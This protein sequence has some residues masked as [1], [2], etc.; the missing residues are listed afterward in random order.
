MSEAIARTYWKNI[1]DQ[2]WEEAEG[3]LHRNFVAEWPQSRER[4]RRA[5]DFIQM[6][7]EYPG[8]H[9]VEVLEALSV[10]DRTVTTVYIHAE[11]TGQKAYATS[12][13]EVTEGK[14]SK[15]TEFWAEPYPAPASRQRW[16]EP[17]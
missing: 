11:D 15:L 4:F 16:V 13:F 7:R 2:K 3:L 1:S 12:W 17:Y 6:N 8:N 10:G 9:H 14:I 5:S